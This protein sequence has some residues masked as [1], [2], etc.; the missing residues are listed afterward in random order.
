VDAIREH[1]HA[2]ELL[3]GVLHALLDT[4]VAKLPRVADRPTY[5]VRHENNFVTEVTD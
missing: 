5:T 3:A 1:R 4:P 2:S